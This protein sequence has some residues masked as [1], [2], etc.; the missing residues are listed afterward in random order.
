MK[1]RLLC[2]NIILLSITCLA[3]VIPR[4]QNI[5]AGEY[6]IGADP[7]EGKGIPITTTYNKSTIEV[8][9]TI[10][11]PQNSTGFIRFKN[12]SGKW[13]APL[14]FKAENF[15]GSGSTLIAG[16][17]FVNNDPGVGK[18]I[19]I[20]NL[21]S[22]TL[23]LPK[24]KLKKG[25]IVFIRVK[26][27][28][29]RWSEAKPVI[30]SYKNIISAQYFIKYNNGSTINP[31]EMTVN[32]S[33]PNY[34][35]FIALSNPIPSITKNDTVYVRFQSED[36]LWGPWSKISGVITS[37]KDNENSMPKEF[38]LYNNYPNPFNP[39]TK[40]K[41]AVPKASLVTLKVYDILGREI[42]TLINEEKSPGNYEVEFNATNLPSG[43]YF[44]KMQAG[45]YSET[46]KM[47]LMR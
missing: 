39:T 30:Y 2:I 31:A 13:S 47:V 42:I 21:S 4:N 36:Y 45:S 46:K 15:T 14:S 37:V 27:S 32:D 43:V 18:G 26:D 22:N 20:T 7:G 40:I 29:L 10:T 19:A 1:R 24:L 16:E 33:L 17:Y 3:Q 11:L 12:S 8:T 44:Y 6:F 35:V 38:M 25:D 41:Y 5:V 28:F 23:T 34:P 9:F